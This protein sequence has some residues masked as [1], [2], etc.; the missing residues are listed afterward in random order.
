MRKTRALAVL[1]LAILGTTAGTEPLPDLTGL[2]RTTHPREDWGEVLVQF[3]LL[4]GLKEAPRWEVSIWRETDTG[5]RKLRDGLFGEARFAELAER[6]GAA[7]LLWLAA[8]GRELG[9][10]RV[11][12]FE[13]GARLALAPEGGDPMRG[14]PVELA[15]SGGVPLAPARLLPVPELSGVWS[16]DHPRTGRVAV[17]FSPTGEGD[18]L[19]ETVRELP[20]SGW[21]FVREGLF[22]DQ[23]HSGSVSRVALERSDGE[24][25]LAWSEPDEP[26]A[27]RRDRVATIYRDGSIGLGQSG[28]GG[29]LDELGRLTPLAGPEARSGTAAGLLD[30]GGLYAY[31][32]AGSAVVQALSVRR[33][34]ATADGLPLYR[35]EPEH[36]ERASAPPAS[37][38][39][40]FP[41]R[42]V[43][44]DAE[45]GRPLL[46]FIDPSGFVEALEAFD[47]ALDGSFSV[48][49]FV[50]GGGSAA[51]RFERLPDPGAPPVS[52]ETAGGPAPGTG[53][54][55]PPSPR[56]AALELAKVRWETLPRPLRADWEAFS[57]WKRTLTGGWKA[58]NLDPRGYAGPEI[59]TSP[60]DDFASFVAEL[61]L[62]PAF[63]DARGRAAYRFPDR[64]RFVAERC[65]GVVESVQAAAGLPPA[66]FPA[67][68][69]VPP[70]AS[71][72]PTAPASA[73]PAP[74]SPPPAPARLDPST[75][76]GVELVVTSPSS[77]S[78]A[79]IA[80]HTLLLVRR[81]GDRPD[82]SDSLVY[83]FVG[84]TARDRA[85][86]V[87]GF[88]YAWRGITGR[89][90]ST[91]S[92]ETF[93]ELAFRGVVMENR[94]VLRYPLSMS[95]AEIE[96]LAERLDA[97]RLAWSGSYRFFGDNC[98][99]LLVD[100]LNA[101]FE[102]DAR[103]ELDEAIVAPMLVLSRL[104]LAGRIDGVAQPEERTLGE[105]ARE[106]AREI[107]ELARRMRTLLPPEG[108]EE[109]DGI[110][111]RS[112]AEA[113]A[114]IR[115]DGLFRE[116]FIARAAGGRAE[117]YAD[118]ADFCV[119]GA[120][121]GDAEQRELCEL[122]LRWL[123]AAF[124]R[125]LF[126]AVPQSVRSSWAKSDGIPRALERDLVERAGYRVRS[127]RENSPEIAALRLASSRLRLH[128]DSSWPEAAFYGLARRVRAERDEARALEAEGAYFGNAYYF[129]KVA[130]GARLGADGAVGFAAWSTAL[131]RGELGDDS[132]SALKRELRLV[133]LD[134]ELRIETASGLSPLAASGGGLVVRSSGTVLDLETVAR[135]DAT[136]R[137][138]FLN[139]G[140][141]LT[142][143]E[144]SS[145]LWDGERLFPGS[146]GP[147]RLLEA[148]AVLN[149]FELADFRH[150]LN[151]AAGVS[152][153]S[154]AGEPGSSFLDGLA[155]GMPLKVEAKFR[156][157]ST[158][159][160]ALRISGEWLEILSED[161]SSSWFA[162]S[163]RLEWPLG[164]RTNARLRLEAAATASLGNPA[165]TDGLAGAELELAAGLSF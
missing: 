91:L 159:G 27:A 23:D 46:R 60:A 52:G 130:S 21:A 48:R 49:A 142:V 11:A 165:R 118:L 38:P 136:D 20:G 44:T 96:R 111:A 117:A 156:V 100:A 160:A 135:P 35:L 121:L 5:L 90:R 107:A 163:A 134:S 69:P 102:P 119:G 129:R 7:A 63:L 128:A 157:A 43:A 108:R 98:A 29:G 153:L 32:A 99:S 1:I 154:G 22:G 4:E 39:S 85:A 143:F 65:P 88:L 149:L 51:G 41:H 55:G 152:L 95:R 115:R 3:Y 132:E 71:P 50:L 53:D 31:R 76:T 79:S 137:P 72:E 83:G 37:P 15:Y 14:V 112:L 73:E 68:A 2:W 13:S 56:A 127:R 161:K 138:A 146:G 116:P 131:Y 30:L 28:G 66:A 59:P 141:G 67:V 109:L 19:V 110:L 125:E 9:S 25:W 105:N 104:A 74:P 10:N 40:A 162:A 94:A 6:D 33:S 155:L 145:V 158:D 57:N 114:E 89:Y 147:A 36:P 123:E 8:D 77:A 47:I 120:G 61:A 97:Q 124:E 86:G 164:R 18:W 12:A 75:I 101:A 92:V 139:P 93:A 133:L 148:R 106:A 78:I 126:Q 84:E 17:R 103:I 34:G 81:A 82:G 24:W 113:G 54:D 144:S 26:R 45:D 58:G 42:L 140:F 122:G 64:A 16:L 150:Y 62:E 80:G 70:P 87:R 151:L